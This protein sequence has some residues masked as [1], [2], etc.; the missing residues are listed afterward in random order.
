MRY[1]VTLLPR[2]VSHW[3]DALEALERPSHR[4]VDQHFGHVMRPESFFNS[5]LIDRRLRAAYPRL[6]EDFVREGERQGFSEIKTDKTNFNVSLDVQHFQPEE[7]NVKIVD[8]FFVI[9]GKHEEKGD[10]HGTISRHFVRKYMIPEECDHEKASTTLSS[11]GILT[12]TVP[13]KPESIVDK[14]VKE[15]KIERTGQPAIDDKDEAQSNPEE[16]PMQIA[17][18]Q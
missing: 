4:L 2:F 13:V 10:D 8:N 16:E 6:L 14:Y 15:L 18:K 5:S 17:Q 7:I 12:I 11:D 3:W 1:R 9:E